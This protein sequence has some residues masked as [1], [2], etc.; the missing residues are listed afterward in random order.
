MATGDVCTVLQGKGEPLQG[1]EKGSILRG[2]EFDIRWTRDRESQQ[3]SYPNR[4]K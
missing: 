3:Y 1:L 4:V 2:A